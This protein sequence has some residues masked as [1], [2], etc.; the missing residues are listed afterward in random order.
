[1]KIS[2]VINT[3]NRKQM[4]FAL[5]DSILKCQGAKEF[6]YIVIDDCSDENY[7]E[8][9]IEKFP[10]IQFV[11]N[12]SRQY[13]IKSRNIG[14]KL[15]KQPLVFFIDDDNE[16]KDPDFFVKAWKLFSSNPQAGII[17]ARSYYFNQPDLIMVG[18][19][20]FNKLT[21]KTTFLGL[22]QQD[23]TH[24]EGLVKTHDVPNAFFVPR[25]V[26]EKTGGFSEEIVQT[27]SEADFAE[28]VRKNGFHVLQASALKV[29]H[30]SDPPDF[31]RLDKRQMGGTPE[32]FYF[33]MRN[34]FVFIK[35]WGSLFQ[36]IFFALVFSHVFTLYYLMNLLRN[37]EYTMV[38]SGVSG[39]LH[40]YI[41]LISGHLYNRYGTKN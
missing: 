31:K 13:L 8:D 30:K 9:I 20:R 17:G 34:R 6:E 21:G 4:L 28:K 5:L 3:R 35:K 23:P 29:Y 10:F 27:F 36:Q 25:H 11:R 26:L 37:K 40:G 2:V 22:N 19:T 41:Y 18:P 14:W 39:V 38:R 33:L 16:V 15:S 24:L 7:T 32:R 1:M 12:I